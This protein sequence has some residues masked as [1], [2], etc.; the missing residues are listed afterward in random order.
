MP[1]MSIFLKV[2]KKVVARTGYSKHLSWMADAVCDRDL[3]LVC[4]VE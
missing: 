1:G 4:A 3:G 2:N